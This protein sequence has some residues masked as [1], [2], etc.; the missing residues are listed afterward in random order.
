[1]GYPVQQPCDELPQ[2]PEDP[3]LGQVLQLGVKTWEENE[4]SFG[5]TIDHHGGD[6]YAIGVPREEG[7]TVVLVQECR[8]TDNRPVVG[9][10]EHKSRC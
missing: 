10:Q 6:G 8:Q 4:A 9:T 2:H 7:E 3:S 1:M 5:Q